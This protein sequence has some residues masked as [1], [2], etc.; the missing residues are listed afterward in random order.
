MLA[1][2]GEAVN[3]TDNLTPQVLGEAGLVQQYTLG[4]DTYTFVEDAKKGRSCTLLI[5]GP[6]DH[7]IAQIK[8]AVRDGLRAVKNVIEADTV[9]AGAG[10]FEVALHDHLMKF[11]DSVSGKQKVGVRA[12]A[13]AM[14]VTPKT[15]A[16]NS[17]LDVQQSLIML[18]E[19]SAAARLNNKWV[20]LRLDNGDMLDPI[21]QG[22]L[23]NVLVK[24]SII[25]SAGEIV[26][27]LLLVDEIMKAGRRGAG[28]PPPQ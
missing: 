21:A 27:Q 4:D 5:K 11:A 26:A 1:C 12:Y 13:D 2:G 28:G 23:D 6:N 10:A 8:D 25:E 14:L 7:T 18:Q 16:E 3:S 9:V 17:G 19:A 24:K 20:G 15:L 22:I